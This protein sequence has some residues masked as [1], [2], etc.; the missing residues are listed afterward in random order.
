M[1]VSAVRRGERHCSESAAYLPGIRS[2]ALE[3]IAPVGLDLPERSHGEPGP[4]PGS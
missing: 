2:G 3:R 4:A 1:T